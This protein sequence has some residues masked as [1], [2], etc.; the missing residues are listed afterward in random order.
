MKSIIE[1]YV[2]ARSIDVESMVSQDPNVIK[3]VA[4]YDKITDRLQQLTDFETADELVCA[5]SAMRAAEI[6]SAYEIGLR[7]GIMFLQELM[8]INLKGKVG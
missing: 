6:E 8:G 2:K 1:V 4:E 5:V 3:E 7:D